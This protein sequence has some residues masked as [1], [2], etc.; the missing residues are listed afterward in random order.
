MFKGFAVPFDAVFI[1]EEDPE[2]ALGCS[3]GG[4]LLDC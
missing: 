3:G 1:L 4:F 2:A